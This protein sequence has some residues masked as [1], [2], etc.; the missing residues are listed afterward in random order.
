MKTTLILILVI[1]TLNYP[2][3]GTAAN[4]HKKLIEKEKS[5]T[6]I[7]KDISK[8]LYICTCKPHTCNPTGEGQ[9]YFQGKYFEDLVTEEANFKD[10]DERF[11]ILWDLAALP[12]GIE[13][14]EA[15]MELFCMKFVGDKKGQ[16]VYESITEPWNT[17]IGYSKKPKTSEIGRITTPWPESKQTHSVNITGFIQNWYAKKMPNYGLMGY[18][19]HTETTN[20]ALFYTSK[21]PDKN[22]RPKLTIVYKRNKS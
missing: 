21:F 4:P 11:L 12:L 8:E 15:K 17:D 2:L 1:C 22:Y 20:S 19:I 10:C 13:I 6:L 14:M 9:I 16:L 3:S 5:D 7:I 18:S